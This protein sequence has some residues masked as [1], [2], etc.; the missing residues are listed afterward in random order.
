M[1]DTK[2]YPI[3]PCND[4][5]NFM[6]DHVLKFQVICISTSFAISDTKEARKLP[7]ALHGHTATVF[8]YHKMLIC[9]GRDIKVRKTT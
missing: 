7:I 3:T 8:N 5:I 6:F 2:N 1:W 4:I 9:G